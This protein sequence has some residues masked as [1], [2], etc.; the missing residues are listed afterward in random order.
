MTMHTDKPETIYLDNNATTAVA[1]EVIEAKAEKIAQDQ[2]NGVAGRLDGYIRSVDHD[3]HH[4]DDIGKVDRS[5]S[6]LAGQEDFILL[7]R[8]AEPYFNVLHIDRVGVSKNALTYDG[9][10]QSEGDLFVKGSATVDGDL[11]VIG[12]IILHP[13]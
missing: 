8:V 1:P 4:V 10:V 13:E 6:A 11:T 12:T 5:G 3:I 9:G 7:P 2:E